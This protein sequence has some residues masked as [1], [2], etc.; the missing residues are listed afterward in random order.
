MYYW[1]F[2]YDL[3]WTSCFLNKLEIFVEKIAHYGCLFVC[4]KILIK[5]NVS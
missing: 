3:I 4:E 5:I 1:T 2:I